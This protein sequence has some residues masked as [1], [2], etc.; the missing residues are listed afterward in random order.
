MGLKIS[1]KLE[2]DKQLKKNWSKY[3]I[4]HSLQENIFD[5]KTF[6]SEG[7]SKKV[8]KG[9]FKKFLIR[10]QTTSMGT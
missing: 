5:D 7:L 9:L 4:F 10:A 1:K 6:L 8:V 3:W 2:Y